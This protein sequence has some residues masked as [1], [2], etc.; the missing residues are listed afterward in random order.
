MGA[1]ESRL[2]D[3]EDLLLVL[4]LDLVDFN[5][6]DAEITDDDEEDEEDFAHCIMELRRNL[7]LSF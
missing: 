1:K 4:A 7:L 5:A 6:D 2:D 3:L